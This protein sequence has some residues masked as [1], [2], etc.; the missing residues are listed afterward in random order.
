MDE[1]GE[2]KATA[3]N[4]DVDEFFDRIQ[5]G[6]VYLLSKAR[7]NLA[8]KKF[9]NLSNEYELTLQRSTEVEE[10]SGYLRCSVSFCFPTPNLQCLD[11]SNV[12]AVRFNFTDIAGLNDLVKD[13]V[14][15]Q[16]KVT[17]KI[18]LYAYA[19]HRRHRCCERGGSGW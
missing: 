19:C 16:F 14:C 13:S 8:K 6:R 7:V 18:L 11:T 12:P 10:V 4:N 2:I 9:S 15:G 3:F 1:T 17:P 5:E